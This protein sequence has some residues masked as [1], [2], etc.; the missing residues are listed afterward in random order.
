MSGGAAS[1]PR[2][3][4]WARWGRFLGASYVLWCSRTTWT[5]RRSNKSSRVSAMQRHR[6]VLRSSAAVWLVLEEA[7]LLAD[8]VLVATAAALGESPLDLALHGGEDYALVVTSTVPIPGFRRIGEVREGR[9]V[10][11]RGAAGER[12]IEARG[13]DHFA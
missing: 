8:A 11:L 12:A 6:S 4:M 5:T 10:V 2:R 7:A 13:F 1:W 3:A 9:G